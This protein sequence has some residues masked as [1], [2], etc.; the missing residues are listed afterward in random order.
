MKLCLEF[1]ITVSVF[2]PEL[3][4]A[5]IAA[6]LRIYLTPDPDVLHPPSSAFSAFVLRHRTDP[7]QGKP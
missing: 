6:R 5:Q 4:P 2:L 1:I 7:N 3:L